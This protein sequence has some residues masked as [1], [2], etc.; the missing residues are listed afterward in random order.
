M[1]FWQIIVVI[2]IIAIPLTAA[3]AV[4]IWTV[5][6]PGSG[7]PPRERRVARTASPDAEPESGA[8]SERAPHDAVREKS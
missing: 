3:V 6:R 8:P 7:P 2:A 1:T 4:T 5:P